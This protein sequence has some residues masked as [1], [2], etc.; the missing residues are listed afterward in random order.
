MTKKAARGGFSSVY[1]ALEHARLRDWLDTTPSPRY[2][3]IRAAVPPVPSTNHDTAAHHLFFPDSDDEDHTTAADVDTDL[4]CPPPLQLT[5]APK[6]RRIGSPV[7]VT[8]VAKVT[9]EVTAVATEV[10]AEV[11]AVAAEVTAEVTAAAAVAA[12][13]AA[14]AAEVTAVA[15]EVAAEVTEVAAEATKVAAEVT[16]VAAEVA[17]V[18]AEVTEAAPKVA[19]EVTTAAVPPP[20]AEDTTHWLLRP[21][22]RLW[23]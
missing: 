22:Y 16:E 14:E 11:T 7:V 19:A 4:G 6:R 2:M 23:W 3:A 13:A 21:L 20:A 17:E 18:A 12:E 9:A 5:P 10:T 1:R 15:V 8:T